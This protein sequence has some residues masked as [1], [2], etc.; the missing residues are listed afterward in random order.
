MRALT[1]FPDLDTMTTTEVAHRFADLRRTGRYVDA[2]VE[3]YAPDVV[4]F[5]PTG[6]LWPEQTNGYENVL[7]KVRTFAEMVRYQ[8]RSYVSKPAIGGDFFSIALNLDLSLNGGGRLSIDGVGVYKV[9]DGLI[10]ME[11]HFYPAMH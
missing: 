6:G 1:A 7:R 2:V 10:V 8:H 3:L 11:Q 5:E 4:S 9:R